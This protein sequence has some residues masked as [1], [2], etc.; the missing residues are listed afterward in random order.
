MH[1]H[2]IDD[3]ECGTPEDRVM[4]YDKLKTLSCG[5]RTHALEI[6]S[7]CGS[8]SSIFCNF[9]DKLTIIE[10][11]TMHQCDDHINTN[12]YNITFDANHLQINHVEMTDEHKHLNRLDTMKYNVRIRYVMRYGVLY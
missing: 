12:S 9:F 7:Y 1:H 2:V 11:Y 4:F 10:N 5:H 8:M 6:G 3:S